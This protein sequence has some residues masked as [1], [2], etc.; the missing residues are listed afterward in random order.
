LD[1]LG[2]LLLPPYE[3]LD[4]PTSRSKICIETVKAYLKPGVFNMSPRGLQVSL[5]AFD[6][7]AEGWRACA[8]EDVGK[9]GVD[10]RERPV[11]RFDETRSLMRQRESGRDPTVFLSDPFVELLDGGRSEFR[12]SR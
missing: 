11:G 5:A 2:L 7:I 6:Q 12:K 3:L 4:R 9:L 8:I 10:K 1:K